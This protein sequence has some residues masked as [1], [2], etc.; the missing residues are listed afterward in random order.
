MR[1]RFIIAL[2]LALLPFAILTAGQAVWRLIRAHE[3]A[4]A[5]LIDGAR[6]STVP[7]ANLLAAAEG[8]LR[9]L[10]TNPGV[11]AGSAA[12]QR[13]LAMALGEV[14]YTGAARLNARGVIVCSDKPVAADMRNRSAEAWWEETARRRALTVSPAHTDPLS[15]RSIVTVS[16]PLFAPE[17][18]FDGA[19]ALGIAT[20]VFDRIMQARSMPGGSVAA[21]LDSSGNLVSASDMRLAAALFP[22]PLDLHSG[23][24]TRTVDD[25]G[26]GWMFAL[27][28]VRNDRLYLAFAQ[29]ETALLA[30]SYLDIASN[31]ALPLLMAVFAF[32]AIWL[33]ADRFVLRWVFYLQ[34]VAR[35]YARGHFA[36]RPEKAAAAAPPEI[37]QLAA[38]LGDM[39]ANIQQ[40][41]RSLRD[42]LEQR[43]LMLREIHH[44]VKNN[45]QVV[46]SLLELESR[47]VREPAAR[48]VLRITRTRINAIALANRVIEEAETQTVVNLRKML[49]EL[50]TLA[51][52]AFAEGFDSATI[53][54]ETPDLHVD[55]DV[56]VPLALWLVEQL[57]DTYR[58]ALEQ[59]TRL[60]LTL[61]A[62]Q[63][64]DGLVVEATL[65][66]SGGI[67]A[68]AQGSP[69]APAYVRQLR[70]MTEIRQ[71]SPDV[72]TIALRFPWTR[73]GDENDK[74]RVD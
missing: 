13:V 47:R 34:R 3:D 17:G 46:A 69:F 58:A 49:G 51:L 54:N 70:G 28:E 26:N 8:V 57:A 42:A 65:I 62:R 48:E 2:V 29:R 39:A 50:A 73:K 35:S 36:L 4:A 27:A 31:V 10:E 25:K 23:A 66:G 68:P 40:R 56:A 24:L 63:E 53:D 32:G 72:L 74:G 22:Q 59:R 6:A 12:C 1:R 37:Q 67:A 64:A 19:L 38:T 71:A 18:S 9:A 7:E 60:A 55:T 41:D 16:L 11:R 45:L 5:T 52:D 43:T 61:M 20:E 33:S 44:R 30:W 14:P 15:K 21:L